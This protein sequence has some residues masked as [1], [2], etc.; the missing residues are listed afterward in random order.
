[1]SERASSV[2]SIGSGEIQHCGIKQNIKDCG[3]FEIVENI[4]RDRP[5]EIKSEWRPT[6]YHV[7]KSHT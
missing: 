2:H 6:Y 3:C 1:M 7:C 5:F 4:F